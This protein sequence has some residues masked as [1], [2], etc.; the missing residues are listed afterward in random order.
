MGTR[1]NASLPGSGGSKREFFGEFSP[2]GPLRPTGVEGVRTA[3]EGF[4]KI[5]LNRKSEVAAA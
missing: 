4:A 3:G 1:W 5:K 2:P